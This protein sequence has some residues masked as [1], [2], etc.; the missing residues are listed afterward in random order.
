VNWR[1]IQTHFKDML[2]VV[3]SIQA[4]KVIPSML[5]QKLGVYSRKNRL[6]LAFRELGRVVRTIFLLEY[7]S[8]KP[9]R[10][11]IRGA[12][13]KIES[14][15]SF[16]DWV[17]FGG[18]VIT[19]ADPVEQ[20]KRIKYMNLV[21]NIIMLHNVVDLTGVLNQMVVSGHQVT[22]SLVQRLSPYM[23][24]H[25]KRFGQY[26]LDMDNLPQPLEI[27]KLNVV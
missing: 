14:F 12:T 7:V 26:V 13:T 19:S 2:Q 22:T 20:E 15:N 1:L 16:R 11:E 9:M 21:A 24:K 18:H 4:G 27:P 5:L 17:A 25:I 8:S 23:T 3:L 10:M 6:Y